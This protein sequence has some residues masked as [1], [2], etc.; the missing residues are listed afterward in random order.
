M[1]RLLGGVA[2]VAA[3]CVVPVAQA[4]DQADVPPPAAVAT[5]VS[6]AQI[7]AA[8]GQLDAIATGLRQRTGVPGMAIS[9]VH[10]DQVVYAKG[11]GVRNTTTGKPVDANTVFELASMSKPLGATVVARAVGQHTVAWT[12]LV[13]KYLPWFKLK[14]PSTTRQLQI[15]D[16]YSHRSGLPDHAGDLLEDLGY[17]RNQVL[18]RLRFLPLTPIRSHYAYT[19]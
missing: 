10:D 4:Q 14:D 7:D 12:D 17:G 2:V 8:V 6:Q 5:P 11:F 15:A 13:T 19:N 1:R 9:V 3:W 18:R 16:L